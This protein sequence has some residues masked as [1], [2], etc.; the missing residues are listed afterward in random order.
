MMDNYWS[1]EWVR[2]KN[3]AHSHASGVAVLGQ[4]D[5]FSFSH[6]AS[7]HLSLSMK[8]LNDG[9]WEGK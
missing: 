6:F 4:I 7:S 1:W 2:M 3:Y 5:N 8:C 9:V